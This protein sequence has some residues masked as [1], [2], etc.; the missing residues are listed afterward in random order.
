M[1]VTG[2]WVG[3]S[4]ELPFTVNGYRSSIWK[5]KNILFCLWKD[6]MHPVY[7]NIVQTKVVVVQWDYLM[8]PNFEMVKKFLK[9]FFLIS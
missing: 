1:V 8:S 9:K 6:K 7:Q 4:G 5:D 2:N 3:K